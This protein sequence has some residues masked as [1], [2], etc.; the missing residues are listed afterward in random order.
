MLG[1][2]IRETLAAVTLAE[3]VKVRR[4]KAQNNLMNDI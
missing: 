1:E 4:E 3:L 2:K